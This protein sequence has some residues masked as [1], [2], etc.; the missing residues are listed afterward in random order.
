MKAITCGRFIIA[1]SACATLG[2]AQPTWAT[3]AAPISSQPASQA[4]E[5][6]ERPA[7]LTSLLKETRDNPESVEAWINLGQRYLDSRCVGAS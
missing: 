7:T 3:S 6:A 2:Y 4:S 5:A 1:A